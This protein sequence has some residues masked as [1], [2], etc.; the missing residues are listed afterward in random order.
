MGVEG[1]ALSKEA[2]FD[3]R[4]MTS[5]RPR[6]LPH[7]RAAFCACAYGFGYLFTSLDHG[8]RRL[9][10]GPFAGPGGARGR[11]FADLCGPYPR[12]AVPRTGRRPW[13]GSFWWRRSGREGRRPLGAPRSWSA[14]RSRKAGI[15]G[16][17]DLCP[18]PLR[19]SGTSQVYGETGAKLTSKAS[20]RISILVI[21]AAFSSA[22]IPG[23]RAPAIGGK[24]LL[25][26]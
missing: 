13:P 20:P 17:G 26:G 7:T 19:R 3:T 16:E 9:G 21:P 14:P 23:K 12:K 18:K 11:S 10:Q 2:I 5:P 25:A 4:W 22:T 1:S 6:M 15:W 8:P 24:E